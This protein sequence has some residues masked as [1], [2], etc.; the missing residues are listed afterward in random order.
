MSSVIHLSVL[1][2]I[3]AVFA[4]RGGFSIYS[5]M[6]PEFKNLSLS[7]LSIM[8][9]QHEG[10]LKI[11]APPKWQKS[12]IFCCTCQDFVKI[13][14]PKVEAKLQLVRYSNFFQFHQIGVI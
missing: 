1:L 7:S 13:T 4:E 12:P 6:K 5:H 9:D 11:A 10:N 3:S 8:R 14:K 2:M